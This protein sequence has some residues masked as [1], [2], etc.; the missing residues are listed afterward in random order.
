MGIS[1]TPVSG[2]LVDRVWSEW[3][4]IPQAPQQPIRPHPMALAGISISEKIEKIRAFLLSS[5]GS[6]IGQP[7]A[8]V[9]SQ[10]DEIAWTLNLR[11]SDVPCNQVVLS[12]ALVTSG[13][14]HEN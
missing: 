10:L 8:L 7:R 6:K 13:D 12:Y 14:K 11:G 4:G 9:L 2:N 3:D 1:L 5:Y